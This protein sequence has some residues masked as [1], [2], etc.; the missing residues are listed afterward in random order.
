MEQRDHF[1]EYVKKLDNASLT[2][3]DA[4][5]DEIIDIVHHIDYGPFYFPCLTSYLKSAIMF[6]G[7][8]SGVSNIKR[9]FEHDEKTVRVK[10]AH[11]VGVAAQALIYYL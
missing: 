9:F 5:L 1:L 3:L 7:I 11:I 6:A 8:E 10:S 4:Q 2:E